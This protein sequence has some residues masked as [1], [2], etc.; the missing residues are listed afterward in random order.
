[1]KLAE[2]VLCMPSILWKNNQIADVLTG[3]EGDQVPTLTPELLGPVLSLVISELLKITVCPAGSELLTPYIS[4]NGFL[5]CSA[6]GSELMTFP[7]TGFFLQRT[8][9]RSSDLYI[10]TNRLIS[11][12]RPGS[13]LLT[14]FQQHA[15]PFLFFF[16]SSPCYFL[17]FSR[18]Y[19]PFINLYP[20][21]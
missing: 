21:P 16:F 7:L 18:W 9:V 5:F 2:A 4:T 19:S 1:M 3:T 13:E 10:F 6:S 11:C 17:Y 20:T 12:S 15:D 14:S 8:R